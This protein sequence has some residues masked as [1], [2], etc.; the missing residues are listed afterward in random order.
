[1]RSLFIAC[2]ATTA[3]YGLGFFM[4]ANGIWTLP[5][6]GFFI[7]I[8]WPTIMAVAMGYF[9]SQSPVITSAIIVLSGALN[10]VIQ[11]VIGFT[12]RRAGPAWG[13]RSC[14]VYS[15]LLIAALTFLWRRMRRTAGY[16]KGV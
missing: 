15:I 16:A 9:G 10:A 1:M 7:A 12:N 14:F 2:I 13:Y 11:F 6:L 8:M 4:G 5:I 3:L